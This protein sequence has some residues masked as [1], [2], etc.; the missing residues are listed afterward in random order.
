[1]VLLTTN[2][3]RDL[4][5]PF[6]RRCVERIEAPKPDRLRL[7]GEAHFRDLNPL[8]HN[9][10]VSLEPASPAEYLDAVR[11]CRSLSSVKTKPTDLEE[12]IRAVLGHRPGRAIAAP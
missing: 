3:E 9:I 6:L 2:E 12:I 1:M 4:P 11:A 5:D 7:I 10:V 8:H